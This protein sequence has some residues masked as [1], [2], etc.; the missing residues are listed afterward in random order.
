MRQTITPLKPDPD[1]RKRI[2]EIIITALLSLASVC[3]GFTGC[4]ALTTVLN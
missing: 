1:K 2:A 4:H 3:F